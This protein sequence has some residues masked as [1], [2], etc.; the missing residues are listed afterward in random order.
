MEPF[1]FYFLFFL[2]YAFLGWCME[3]IVCSIPAKKF[4]NRGFLVGPYCPIYGIA[5]L[6]MFLTL[7]KYTED[8]PVLFLIVFTSGS[9]LEYLTSFIMEK[10]FHA[11]WWD[12]SKKK[13]N[14]NGRVCLENSICFG[15]LG[16]ILMYVTNPFVVFLLNSFSK[17]LLYTLRNKL[18]C[19]IHHW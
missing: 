16:C 7:G 4:I 13:F 10:L 18:T 5:A 9:L 14:I 2:L 3:V 11:R 19:N 8:P 6:A 17:N 12:Y 1:L 15:I